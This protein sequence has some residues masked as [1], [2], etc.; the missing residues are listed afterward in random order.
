MRLAFLHKR[1]AP[2]RGFSMECLSSKMQN[3]PRAR[4]QRAQGTVLKGGQ[5]Q[6]QK[7]EE[8]VEM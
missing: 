4:I 5:H 7:T 8:E 3:C 1:L 2:A 6:Q